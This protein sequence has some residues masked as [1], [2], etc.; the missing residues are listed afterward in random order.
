MKCVTWRGLEE[1]DDLQFVAGSEP[2]IPNPPRCPSPALAFP[3]AFYSVG[4]D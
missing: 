2:P 1:A 3:R 4:A